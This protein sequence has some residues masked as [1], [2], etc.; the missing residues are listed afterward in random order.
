MLFPRALLTGFLWAIAFELLLA[1]EALFP[2]VVLTGFLCEVA[3]ELLL[4]PVALL[5]PR[6]VLTASRVATERFFE[7]LLSRMFLE[8]DP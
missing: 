8:L 5:F 1:L 2:R 6:A 7:A 3:L 4:T